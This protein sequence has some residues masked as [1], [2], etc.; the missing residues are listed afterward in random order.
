M[1]GKKLH[2]NILMLVGLGSV[3]RSTLVAS[4][5]ASPAATASVADATAAAAPGV[6]HG[7]SAVDHRVVAGHPARPAGCPVNRRCCHAAAG[8]KRPLEVSLHH[9]LD[10][11]IAEDLIPL[12]GHVYMVISPVAMQHRRRRRRVF[13]L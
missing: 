3:A 2:H 12:C 1:H 5:A 6:G 9:P 7:V 13:L 8:L 4:A 10:E 11:P